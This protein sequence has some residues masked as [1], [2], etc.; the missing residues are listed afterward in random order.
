MPRPTVAPRARPTPA[1]RAVGPTP[2]R[3]VRW[4]TAAALVGLTVAAFHG[5]VR[6]DWIVFDDPMYVTA[7]DHVTAGLTLDGVRYFLGHA[8]G[9]NWHPL[10]SVGH[11]LD[12]QVFGLD[13]AA[14]HAVNLAWHVASALLLLLGLFGLSGSW[15]RSLAVATL[16]AVHPLRVESVA[17]IAERKDVQSTFFFLLT[18]EAY[19][20]WTKRPG[21]LRYAGVVAA[22]GL[23]LLSKSM[24]VTTPFV[25][26]LLDVWP[27]RRWT[28]G[29]PDGARTAWERVREK[30]PLFAMA[31]GAAVITVLVQRAYGALNAA[32]PHTRMTQLCNV[33]VSYGMY[34][35]KSIVPTRLAFL[36]PYP[37]TAQLAAAAAALVG[38]VVITIVAIRSYR[39]RPYLVVGWFWFLGTLVPVIGLVQTGSQAWADHYSYIPC[40]GLAIAGVWWAASMMVGRWARIVG[41]AVFLLA[42]AWLAQA[43]ARQV[44]RWRDT[45][46]LANWTER[47]QPD[48]VGPWIALGN[49]YMQRG[50]PSLAIVQYEQALR[51][52][53][54][55]TAVRASLAAAMASVGRTPEARVQLAR[56]VEQSPSARS[57][58]DLGYLDFRDERMADAAREFER[59]LAL[60][61]QDP[62]AR[63]WLAEARARLAATPASRDS[64]AGKRRN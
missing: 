25:L 60:D 3:L 15:W 37:R 1:T 8:H 12:V 43:T 64:S 14:H 46:T 28:P 35:V 19:R 11:M 20:R 31:L 7:N 45:E 62:S 42:V 21:P 5:V 13:P 17:W 49:L 6:N 52:R 50:Q 34:V 26:L 2:S 18:L 51:L 40:I 58:F 55:N 27:L 39:N 4:L 38:L 59:A 32:P 24:L 33:L 22:F 53:P 36:Y 41:I 63:E 48:N 10:T 54:G 29:E 56:V 16:F 23:G 47:L 44:T 61:P 9:G 57:W 30:W